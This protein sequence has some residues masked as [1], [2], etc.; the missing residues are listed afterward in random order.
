VVVVII[1]FRKRMICLGV[2]TII[3]MRSV[4]A[5]QENVFS[6]LNRDLGVAFG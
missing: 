1:G 3:D 5:D 2:N 4:Y 6:T